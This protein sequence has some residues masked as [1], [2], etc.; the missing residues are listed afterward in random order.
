MQNPHSEQWCA[1]SGFHTLSHFLHVLNLAGSMPGGASY[2]DALIVAYLQL[3]HGAGVGPG[4]APVG[5]EAEHTEGVE[6]QKVESS[7]LR[8]RDA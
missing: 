4:G 2:T 3:R 8:E 1:L 7:Q 5:D 6:E